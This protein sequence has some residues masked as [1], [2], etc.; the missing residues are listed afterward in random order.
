MAKNSA[1]ADDK[2]HLQTHKKQWEIFMKA[3]TWAT[4]AIITVLALLALVLL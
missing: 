1:L 4:F 3:A 2:E